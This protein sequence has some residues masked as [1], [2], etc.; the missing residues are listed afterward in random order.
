MI[1]QISACI[2]HFEN[3]SM[4]YCGSQAVLN[5]Q[6]SIPHNRPGLPYPIDINTNSWLSSDITEQDLTAVIRFV[7]LYFDLAL[8]PFRFVVTQSDLGGC[9][10]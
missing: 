5:F 6:L 10:A 1:R 3:G 4:A 9:N 8:N 7:N 2:L